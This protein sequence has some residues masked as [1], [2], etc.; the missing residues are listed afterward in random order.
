MLLITSNHLHLS[1]DFSSALF[2]GAFAV[3]IALDEVCTTLAIAPAV[4]KYSGLN[5]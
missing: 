4:V 2:L 5:V 3:G 1:C